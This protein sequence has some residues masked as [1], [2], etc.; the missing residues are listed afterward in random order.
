MSRSHQPVSA[1]GEKG[2]WTTRDSQELLLNFGLELKK[3]RD[4]TPYLLTQISFSPQYSLTHWKQDLL[5]VDTPLP[6]KPDD[7]IEGRIKISRNQQWRRHLRVLL[8]YR[9]ISGEQTSQ[10]GS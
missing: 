7:V 3:L 5:M 4:E 9:H 2:Y 6:V 1:R 10:V 8:T